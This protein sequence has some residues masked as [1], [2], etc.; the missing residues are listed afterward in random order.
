MHIF[1]LEVRS[2]NESDMIG[3]SGLEIWE[4]SAYKVMSLDETT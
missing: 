1:S 4:S 2:S 3:R